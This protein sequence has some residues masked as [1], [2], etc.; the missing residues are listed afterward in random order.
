[1]KPVR[2]SV[3]IDVSPASI[4]ESH[5]ILKLLKG[6]ASW[7]QSKGI[8]QWHPD[9][10]HLEHVHEFFHNGCEFFLAR[11]N[12]EI[13]GTLFI[14]WSDPRVWEELDDERSGYIHKFAVGRDYVGLG[15]GRQLLGWA[16][17][18]IRDKGKKIRLDC[19]AENHR[20]NQYYVESG[21]KYVKRLEWE[22][23]WK[24]SLYE[25]V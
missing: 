21:Y 17:Q 3:S 20:L 24:I 4:E 15:I 25:K 22:N 2:E 16:E 9:E 11:M 1:M 6:A 23:G 14:C 19:M 10:I 8:N 7:I 5:E 13:V 12:A 18:Y